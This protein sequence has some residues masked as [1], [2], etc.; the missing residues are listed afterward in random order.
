MYTAEVWNTA[1]TLEAEP[2][3]LSK[4]LAEK[5]AWEIAGR[6]GLDLVAINPVYVDG[7]VLSGRVDATS[8]K[9]LKA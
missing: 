6:E 4:T 3:W 9:L 2:Y 1:S 8:I 5:A 7:P